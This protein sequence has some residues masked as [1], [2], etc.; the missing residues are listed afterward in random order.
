[1][2]VNSILTASQKKMHDSVEHTRKELAAIR[3]GRASLAILEG[4]TV[5]YY[6][7]DDLNRLL[8]VLGITGD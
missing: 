2:P 5:E 6:G 4:I 1:M 7:T 8:G 3:T